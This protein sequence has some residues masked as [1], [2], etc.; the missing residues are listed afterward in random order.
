MNKNNLIAKYYSNLLS[1]HENALFNELLNSD[2]A[3]RAATDKAGKRI[4]ELNRE[5]DETIPDEVFFKV[6]G[7][8]KRTP[9]KNIKIKFAFA[10]PVLAVTAILIYAAVIWFKSPENLQGIQNNENYTEILLESND[11]S[12]YTTETETD[13]AVILE[14]IGI[15][16]AVEYYNIDFSRE[17]LD[18]YLNDD[19]LNELYKN[20]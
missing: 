16:S 5:I 9:E 2:A 18:E 8:V 13:F 3:F 14:S 10:L 17:N 7:K 19:E 11:Y 4:K 15:E 20:L 12:Y 6:I 1:E